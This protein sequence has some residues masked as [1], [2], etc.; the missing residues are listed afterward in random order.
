MIK[1]SKTVFTTLIF[2]YAFL[3]I[4][5]VFVVISS[6][7]ESSIPGI[8]T[9]FSLKWF[10]AVFTD[11]TL[12]RAAISSIEIAVI[13]ATAST[14]LGLL[15]AIATTPPTNNVLSN[16]LGRV[17][18]IPII[19]PE[20][21]IGFSLLMLF[22]AMEKIFDFPK[23]RGIATV[24]IG[25]TMATMAYVYTTVKSRLELFD[26]TLDDAARDL[27]ATPFVA[28]S[29]V[30]MPI[31]WKSVIS[32]WLLAFTLSLDDLVIASFLS[33]PGATTLPIVIFSN[34]KIG[35]TPAINAFATIF[36]SAI[37]LCIIISSLFARNGKRAR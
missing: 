10:R 1:L 16:L 31:I 13:S 25:H 29:R 4:P 2:G 14:L 19:V 7:S 8:W 17:V 34:I 18:V 22:V 3:Y 6:F 26:R 11:E 33:G 24:A 28:F 27:G 9:Q 35:V 36:I 37:L 15:A 23:S 30:K 5:L 12:L 20:I 21:V 32:G